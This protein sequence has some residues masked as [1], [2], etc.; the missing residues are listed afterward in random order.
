MH[1]DP[2]V[3]RQC[4]TRG[5]VIDTRKCVG[6]RRRRVRCR[7]CGYLWNNYVSLMNPKRAIRRWIK[8]QTDSRG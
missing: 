1:L 6:Y 2:M 8:E 3:C 5:T 7:A 4:H